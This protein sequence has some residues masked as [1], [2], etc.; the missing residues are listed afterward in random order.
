MAVKTEDLE[1]EL[2]EALCG[3]IRDRLPEAEAPMA[4]S[5]VRQFYHWVPAADLSG[6]GE[7]EL[8]GVAMAQW[9]VFQTR[10]PPEVK[11]R[12]YNPDE[13][14]NGVRAPHTFIQIV[15]D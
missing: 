13:A 7:D 8:Y 2:I 12:V 9:E 3:L 15:S 11:V 6:H 14:H 10:R 1:S 4:Q 5:F